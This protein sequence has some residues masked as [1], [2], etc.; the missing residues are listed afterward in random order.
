M[1]PLTITAEYMGPLSNRFEFQTI[2]GGGVSPCPPAPIPVAAQVIGIRIKNSITG[3]IADYTYTGF[4]FGC[5]FSVN[6]PT[7]WQ[8]KKTPLFLDVEHFEGSGTV[9]SIGAGKTGVVFKFQGP[10]ERKMMKEPLILVFEGWDIVVGGEA[11][12][13][14]RWHLR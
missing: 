6:R 12:I 1:E 9:T 3:K 4:G 7:G 8:T 5:G 10:V 11:D 14:G 2:S 13:I